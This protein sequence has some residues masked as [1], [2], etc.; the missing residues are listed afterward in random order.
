MAARGEKGS[1]GSYA[2]I[3]QDYPLA[4]PSPSPLPSRSSSPA[5]PPD[6]HY[7]Y[8][9]S[10]RRTE[11]D[12]AIHISTNFIPSSSKF[13]HDGGGGA[14]NHGSGGPGGYNH[15][16]FAHTTSP[17]TPS[18]NAAT[19]NVAALCSALSTS[20]STGLASSTV[21]AIRE[22]SGPN[23]FE[24]GAKDPVW[25]KFAAQ[26]YESP[27]ILLLLASAAISA[28]VGN[29]D[30]AASI[31]GA[32]LIV[33]TGKLFSLRGLR[34]FEEALRR[35]SSASALSPGV[36]TAEHVT[37]CRQLA[38]CKSNAPRNLSM[39][40]TSS[41]H[42]TA[43]SFGAVLPPLLPG[44]DWKEAHPPRAFVPFRSD[45]NK[46]TQLANVLVPGDL[47]TFTTGDRIPADIRLT[48][49][50]HLEIDESTLTGE[51]HPARKQVEA[52][53]DSGMGVG[54]LPISERRN[55]AFMGT[56][57]RNGRGEGI[58]VG[59][60]VQSEFGVVFAMMQEV[61]VEGFFV[62]SGVF[63]LEVEGGSLFVSFVWRWYRS[64]TARRRYSS[65]WTSSQ[66][67]SPPS[68]LAL[69]ES[70]F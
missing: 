11:P 33:V 51:T 56:L 8:S 48:V 64:G 44:P 65:P 49:A 41:Y 39:P 40:S 36:C 34:A 24:V 54:G 46:T 42:T 53:M 63:M 5:L 10:L 2:R 27:L 62:F 22:L 43:T 29:Y 59:T 60:G 30:D 4:P 47:I 55:I 16:P 17:V 37:P 15:H 12:T 61:R 32:I 20:P 26:F 31:V 14:G 50:H 52:I 57:V 21:P 18:S 70:S 68:R 6:E 66:R 23:E 35:S 9:T 28:V 13:Q 69:S 19:Q 1:A 3:T 25:K 38:S 45:G 58:V 67:S 7:A